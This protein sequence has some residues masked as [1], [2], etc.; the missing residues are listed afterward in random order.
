MTVQ[1]KPFLEE[2][3]FTFGGPD[4]PSI[5]PDH[6]LTALWMGL[7]NYYSTTQASLKSGTNRYFFSVIPDNDPAKSYIN[8]MLGVP[9]HEWLVHYELAIYSTQR[10]FELYIGRM[11][12]AISPIITRKQF[13]ANRILRELEDRSEQ[14][15]WVN[16]RTI[17]YAN[18]LDRF[19]RLLE[20]TAELPEDVQIPA[21]YR[22]FQRHREA[23]DAM[24]D[25]RNKIAHS[26]EAVLLEYAFELLFVNYVLP[27]AREVIASEGEV[28]PMNRNLYCGLNVI[29]EL[30]EVKLPF[31]WLNPAT[32]EEV[33]KQLRWVNHLKER[34][35]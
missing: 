10:F 33:Q 25:W 31:D 6:V 18:L 7:R 19:F 29:N 13:R 28:I 17:G 2:N 11:L 1:L 26:G 35:L 21:Q 20:A 14:A 34:P 9:S 16:E 27:I 15:R 4:A 12:D 24:A 3:T 8:P 22:F 32:Y 23:L 5:S 30:C